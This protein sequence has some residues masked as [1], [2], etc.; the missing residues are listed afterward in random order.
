MPATI[1]DVRIKSVCALQDIEPADDEQALVWLVG[2]EVLACTDIEY[3]ESYSL[4]LEE[5]EIVTVH[6]GH[7]GRVVGLNIDCT[8]LVDWDQLE[9]PKP[10]RYDQVQAKE[11][12]NAF[13]PG[14]VC[15]LWSNA[16]GHLW[17]C[18]DPS[19]PGQ[20][21]YEEAPQDG[22]FL[23]GILRPS[24][25]G[26]PGW[27]LGDVFAKSVEPEATSG[28]HS[29]GAPPETETGQKYAS[30]QRFL[31]SPELSPEEDKWTHCS[32]EIEKVGLHSPIGQIRVRLS[33]ANQ[34]EVQ[35][36]GDGDDWGEIRQLERQ[37][38]AT[39]HQLQILRLEDGCT[40]GNWA[41]I[42]KLTVGPM[43]SSG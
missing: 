22:G 7:S 33:Q 28:E 39:C 18:P 36:C 31:V 13:G 27:W 3:V 16:L 23:H 11:G 20:C 6:A 15:G 42:Q 9:A 34:L 26:L 32:K 37:L 29:E 25:R 2:T 41:K 8:L 30:L 1:F 38:P 17:I 5:P 40:R 21:F 35:I 19:N 12:T 24:C 43:W 14:S 10:A 4:E